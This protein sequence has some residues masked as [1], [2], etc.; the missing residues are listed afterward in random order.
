VKPEEIIKAFRD[1][2]RFDAEFRRQGRIE[3]EASDDV[4]SILAFAKR[5][6]DAGCTVEDFEDEPN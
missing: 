6:K 1:S 3:S 2:L 5:L 4:R